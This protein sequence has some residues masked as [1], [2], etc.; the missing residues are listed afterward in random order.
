MGKSHTGNLSSKATFLRVSLYMLLSLM[1][2]GICSAISIG[3]RVQCNANGTNVRSGAGTGFATIAGSPVNSGSLGVILNGPYA[4]SGFNWYL[5]RWDGFSLDGYTA[6]QFLTS[7]V[8][9]TPVTSSPGGDTAPGTT[10][11]ST[12]PIFQWTV[13]GATGIN[14]YIRDTDTNILQNFINVVSVGGSWT[15]SSGTLLSGHK[16]KWNMQ[17]TNS[18]GSS[19]VSNSLYFQIASSPGTIDARLKNVDGN[20]ATASKVRFKLYTSP[21]QEISG[22]NP[23]TFSNITSDSYLLEG[24]QNGTFLGEEFWNSEPAVAVASGTTVIASITRKYPYASSVVIKNNSTNAVIAAGQSLPQSTTLRAEVTVR[25]DVGSALNSKVRFLLDKDKSS[26]GFDFDSG[27]SSLGSVAGG[28]GTRTYSFV[29]NPPSTGQFYYALEVFTDVNGNPIRTDSYTWTQTCLVSPPPSV[30][31]LVPTISNPV[32]DVIPAINGQQT[33]DVYGD[34]ISYGGAFNVRMLWTGDFDDLDSGQITQVSATQFQVRVNIGSNPDSWKIIV[35][36][37]DGQVSADHNFTAL[38]LPVGFTLQTPAY[39]E[40]SSVPTVQLT[41][42]TSTN[43][44]SFEVL[45]NDV[46]I[47]TI[48][49]SSPRSYTDNIGLAR[50]QSYTYKVNSRNRVGSIL[51][52]ASSITIPLANAPIL[53]LTSPPNGSTYSVGSPISISWSLTGVTTG[54]TGLRLS[55]LSSSGVT[56]QTIPLSQTTTTYNWVVPSSF[57]TSTGII[58]IETVGAQSIPQQVAI[59]TTQVPV[60]SPAPYAIITLPQYPLNTKVLPPNTSIQFSGTNSQGNPTAYY[61]VFSDGR[62]LSGVTVNHS[63]SATVD[64]KGWVKLYLNSENSSSVASFAFT[65]K[66]AGNDPNEGKSLDPVNSATGAFLLGLDLMPVSGRGLPFL[67]QAYY[68]SQSYRPAV[69]ASGTTVATSE[70][71]PGALGYGWSHSF[72]TYV[73]TS[74]SEDG[75]RVALVVFGDGHAEK[76]T[77]AP[78]DATW[79]SPP[80]VWSQL[81]ESTSG[82]FSLTTHAHLRHDF[83]ATKRLEA[84]SDRHGHK[85][86][87]VWEDVPGV[88]GPRRIQKV[89]LPGGPDDGSQKH[90]VLFSYRPATPSFLWKLEDPMHHFIEFT[91]DV[92]GDFV[93]WT[94]ERNHTTS[95]TYDTLHQ[96]LTGKD[97]KNHK[98]VENFY[99]ADRRTWKQLDPSENVTLFSYNFPDDT[100]SD[101]ITT[102]TRLAASTYAANDN[103]NEVTE[104]VHDSKLRRTEHRVRVEDP[105][106]PAGTFTWHSEKWTYDPDTNDVLTRTNRRNFTTR[107]SWQNGNLT[108][109]ETPDTAVRTLEYTDAT[110]PRLPTL[111]NYPDPQVKE[112]RE[113]NATGDLIAVTFPYDATQPNKNKRTFTVNALGQVTMTKDAN[114]VEQSST[115]DVWGRLK[116]FTDGEQ[117]TSQFE[118]DDNGRKTA[119]IDPLLYR[120]D[121]VFNDAGNVWKTLQD[122]PDNP[123]QK[124]VTEITYDENELATQA[125]DPLAH[126]TYSYRD[127]QGRVWKSEDHEHNPTIQRFNAF[128]YEVETENAKGGITRR[129]YNFAGYLMTESSPA[130]STNVITYKRDANGNAT[131]ITDGDGVRTTIEYDAMDRAIVTKRWKTATEFEQTRTSYNLLGQKEWDEDHLGVKTYYHYNLAGDH[132]RTV[133]KSG[134]EYTFD[135]DL[136]GHLKSATHTSSTG[137][138]TRHQEYNGRYQLKKR[139]DENGHSEEFFYD[140]AGNLSRHVQESTSATPLETTFVHDSLNRLT[141]INPPTGPPITFEYDKARR[142]IEM[143]DPT[144]TTKWTHSTLG[145]VA[146]IEMPNGLKLSFDYDSLGATQKITYPGNRPATYVTDAAGRFQSVTDW[147]SRTISQTYTAGDRPLKLQFPNGVYTDLAHDSLGR[148]NVVI[149]RKG[150]DPAL[151]HLSYGFNALGKIDTF[152]DVQLTEPES[153]YTC[154]Y[155]KA[156]ELLS[157]AGTPVTHDGRGN[158]KTA[159]LSPASPA[160]DSLTWDF[161]NR[162]TSGTV[163]AAPFSNTFNGLG[164]RTATTRNGATTGFLYDDRHAMPRIMAE[165]NAA[166]TPTAFYLYLGDTLLAR[167]LPDGSALWYHPDRQGNIVLLTDGSGSTAADY[168]YDPNGVLISTSGSFAASNRFRYLGGLGVW[169]NDDGTLHARARSYHPRLGSFLSNDPLFGSLHDGQSLNRYVYAL[170]DPFGFS[171]PSGFSPVSPPIYNFW[172]TFSQDL[173]IRLGYIGVGFVPLGGEAMDLEVLADP[174]ASS[175]EKYI[176]SV[177]LAASAY[178]GGVTPNFGG[179]RRAVKT[180]TIYKVPGTATPSGKPYVGRH[181]KPEPQK[182]RASTDGRDRTQAEVIDTYD[183]S[184]PIEGRI[185]EQAAIDAEGGVPNLDNK[186]NEIRK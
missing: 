18:V 128:G 67:F 9:S 77:R 31:K 157:I 115:F 123:G 144:G 4:G 48:L 19:S 56:Y 161:A 136:E 107:F 154:T 137:L 30:A 184:K 182:T 90:E 54:I 147:S 70:T 180:G 170:G 12:T 37:S 26:T 167:I 111:I 126:L 101:R 21:T 24:Y 23:A 20:L 88:T 10:I 71:P 76:Y 50:T 85:L 146:S 7:V 64:G 186:R 104:D 93:S 142:R 53:T 47:A 69:T 117:K 102:I 75:V 139:I 11:S 36:N 32:D 127:E 172:G 29:F 162:L 82:L 165:T 168:Q 152:P 148:L 140:D 143:T 114:N 141:R 171:D 78:S 100:T 150:T 44:E 17:G 173:A 73:E 65:L 41:W 166:G 159:K 38:P 109:V 153:T 130:P 176:A 8:P 169:D 110:N 99:N 95:Y 183:I 98:F 124:L 174:S 155:G 5:I 163:G 61:W 158:L 92:K 46:V 91:Q 160:T 16:Y 33:I 15:P 185:K 97:A 39:S 87:I 181:N 25:N 72:E 13:A 58:K 108:R 66:G 57:I 119:S 14:I 43:A 89:V 63:F 68:N 3:D 145:Q 34:N 51:S 121:T 129:T 40:P 177:S 81:D 35:T 28:G 113:Y 27:F 86:Q 125:S 84:I 83:D 131:E 103:R 74:A 135:Y 1:C 120:M 175:F 52:N 133:S 116:T 22:S 42:G 164:H 134:T 156:N 6:S 49:T 60:N 45:R 2:L 149:H 55:I 178:S 151:R 118:F 105:T 106:Q 132:I 122:D 62:K 80:G 179:I 79:Q 59:T 112:K 94:N 96:L 138:A